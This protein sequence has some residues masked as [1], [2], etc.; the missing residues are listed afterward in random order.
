M[1]SVSEISPE[2][3]LRAVRYLQERIVFFALLL[4]VGSAV[5]SAVILTNSKNIL[6]QMQKD[7]DKLDQEYEITQIYLRDLTAELRAAGLYVNP[8]PGDE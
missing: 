6:E 7:V 5:A 2:S 3:Y 1:S 4:A 8:I